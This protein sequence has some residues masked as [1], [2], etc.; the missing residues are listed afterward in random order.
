MEIG[1]LTAKSIRNMLKR[2][3]GLQDFCGRYECTA[4]ELRRKVR[5]L[6]SRDM[7]TAD[8]LIGQ[9]ED[10]DK[11]PKKWWNR[12]RMLTK[13]TRATRMALK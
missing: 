11:K 9:M 12:Q 13:P 7:H 8:D 3:C 2:G 1:T 10:N 5:A 4:D 6:Y